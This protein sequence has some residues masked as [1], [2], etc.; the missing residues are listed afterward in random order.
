MGFIA[1]LGG[2]GE[3]YV[4]GFRI[5]KVS[6]HWIGLRFSRWAAKRVSNALSK[7]QSAKPADL[8]VDLHKRADADVQDRF[9]VRQ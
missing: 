1:A 4:K 7:H 6:D 3:G 5:V 2:I 8:L 9:D